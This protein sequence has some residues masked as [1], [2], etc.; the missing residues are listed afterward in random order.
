MQKWWESWILVCDS[1]FFQVFSFLCFLLKQILYW[2]FYGY[3]VFWG[4]FL[5]NE[6]LFEIYEL[7]LFSSGVVERIFTIL[8][9]DVWN[10]DFSHK[11]VTIHSVSNNL[12]DF[13]K[14]KLD[15]GISFRPRSLLRPSHLNAEDIS[16]LRKVLF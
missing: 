10:H 11:H 9:E 16:V 3:V 13:G 14:L 7:E 12:C 8:W 1:T 5:F 4:I 6:K 2:F 15:E